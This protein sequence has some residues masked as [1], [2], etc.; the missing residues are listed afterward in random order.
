MGV[1]ASTGQDWKA[2]KEALGIRSNLSPTSIINNGVVITS[3]KHSANL[4]NNF[5]IE[6]VK[7]LRTQ[8]ETASIPNINPIDNL[9]KWLQSKDAIPQFRLKIIDV[10]MLRKILR[11][12]K[13][14][15]SHGIDNIDSY[16]LKLA[17]PLMEEAL[18]HL[19]NLSIES[20]LFSSLW[21]PQLVFPMHKKGAKTEIKNFR[22]VS[23]LVE[24]GKM[25][26]YSIYY[27]VIEH[28]KCNNLFHENHH[29]SLSDHSTATALLQLV[30]MW[31][32]AAE[33]KK[34]SAT[35]LLDQHMTW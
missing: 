23:H 31:I 19:I 35:L 30:D 32:R 4:F 12:M 17:G 28:F 5:F 25:V 16:S 18:L 33:N 3:P 14:K 10:N 13:G 11:G 22:P 21:K 29:G 6:K 34:F 7:L 8:T 2:A 15:R 24:I 1:N 27:Q 9:Q 26:E 20:G